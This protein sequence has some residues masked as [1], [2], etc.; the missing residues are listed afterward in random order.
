MR[1][2]PFAPLGLLVLT[3]YLAC[4]PAPTLEQPAPAALRLTHAHRTAQNGLT[5][6]GL[7]QNGLFQNGLFQNGL[8]QNGLFQNGLFQNSLALEALW[9][10]E[11]W[12]A[13]PAALAVLRDNV[14]AR[15]ALKYVY[16]CAK[17][18]AQSKIIALEGV[19][20]ELHGLIGLAPEPAQPGDECDE[21][22]QQR[23]VTACVL[24]RTN[25]YGLPV[26]ISMRAP[27]DAPATVKAALHVTDDE[28]AAYPL[29]EGA[30]YG[31]LF[32]Q[33]PRPGD[34]AVVMAPKFYGCAGPGSNIPQVTKRF[35]SSQGAGGPIRVPGTC[36]PRPE[37]PQS[38]C[39]G[40]SGD[41]TTGAMHDCYERVDPNAR[42]EHYPEVITVYLKQPIEVC[43]NSV[44]EENERLEKTCSSDCHPDSWATSFPSDLSVGTNRR[45]WA[46]TSTLDANDNIVIAG[47]DD[48]VIDLGAGPLD[49]GPGGTMR[50]VLAKYDPSGQI[51]WSERF[52]PFEQGITPAA[53]AVAPDGSIMVAL[54]S[55]ELSEQAGSIWLGKFTPEGK[56][57]WVKPF[58][59]DVNEDGNVNAV[60]DA[61]VVDR[62]G[63][64]TVAGHFYGVLKFG[65]TTLANMS[66]G[67]T[68][69]LNVSS[70][71][72]PR[73]AAGFWRGFINEP[74]RLAVDPQGN[75]LISIFSDSL[76][77]Q[78]VWKLAASSGDHLWS[79]R[80]RYWGVAA[81]ADGN[82]YATGELEHVYPL[83]MAYDFPLPANAEPG[84][85][86]V[87]KY[88]TATDT[89]LHSQVV[90]A[91][92]SDSVSYCAKHFEGR[93]LALDS[94][95]NVVVG[96]VGGNPG[97]TIDFG[98]GPFPT[99][100]TDDVFVV[101]F[102]PQLAPL[103]VKQV[104]MVLDGTE[105]GMYV[106]SHDHLIMSGTF[107]GSM[108]FDD[109]LLVSHIPEQ[110]E[111]GNTFLASFAVPSFSD[112]T[113]PVV[114]EPHLPKPTTL[115]ATSD[116]GAEV[117]FMPPTSLDSGH[118]GV[119]VSCSPPP[120]A[121]F[122][123]GTTVVTCTA[124]DPLGNHASAS[125]PVTVVDQLGPAFLNVPA[126]IT[127]TP[128]PGSASAVVTFPLPLALDQID[129][130]RAV[131]CTPASGSV[132]SVGT[133]EVTCS[134]ADAHGHLTEVSFDV[135]VADVVPPS[136][137]HVPAPFTVEASE[138]G[139]AR[140]TFELPLAFDLVDEN[141]PITCSPASGSVF[142]LGP[143]T[144]TCSASDA[145]GN[146]AQATFVVTVVDT[147]PPT[148]SAPEPIAAIA[149]SSQGA[150]VTYAASATDVASGPLTP[151]CSLPS[152]SLFPPGTTTVTCSATDPS[153]NTATRSFPVTVT[154]AWSGLLKPL[155]S[156]GQA[157]RVGTKLKVRFR[158]TEASAG[159]VDL[160]AT[161][162]AVKASPK[163]L[164]ALAKT[165]SPEALTGAMPFR[166]DPSKGWYEY[167][168][169][170]KSM[171][172]GEW[173]LRLQ[174]G[175]GV[176][177]SVQ[178]RLWR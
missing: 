138:A 9:Q 99:Y 130:S 54:D 171:A 35:C 71:G 67:A 58:G 115:E 60:V 51:L 45:P 50:G 40:V 74:R 95:G 23:W 43:G 55:G 46:K 102:S 87:V 72:T 91:S 106:N 126:P 97:G 177:R 169:A 21:I 89:L 16:E 93:E 31:N 131:T 128:P 123:L 42:G 159:I 145:Q 176:P 164:G 147:T 64:P 136:I 61:L 73:W 132:F 53:V 110:R 88:A 154:F 137:T 27:D 17:T 170:T 11:T 69:V 82:V 41:A 49:A 5:S 150:V 157:F 25:A 111:V 12:E 151:T 59:E 77:G 139:G 29:R 6:N 108:Q 174:F 78:G 85:F 142:P 173:D 127:V 100:A 112:E 155:D 103:W 10:R 107:S 65:D 149:T 143:T 141:V 57:V 13:N 166:Y 48:S 2:R 163:P 3:G 62:N 14:Y 83:D 47:A 156:D 153:G 160:P 167:E 134:A 140:P 114:A 37:F 119:S 124:T 8:F 113:P 175:D 86:F 172:P 96:V 158:L 162:S 63:N 165:P 104:P 94:A 81:D 101:A 26:D 20:L 28:R 122:P 4:T 34:G 80:G 32:R 144:V 1:L 22:C 152:G 120:N 75:V 38:A 105:R 109:H 70:Q 146:L 19:T 68:F 79:T 56:P 125:F 117:F 129:G 118:A 135:T 66:D 148:L 15:D 90:H 52:G 76:M 39:Q 36:E 121:V 30:F 92:C 116:A 133:R 178:I 161:L 33:A 18:P 24:A 44:C 168:L 84:D 7:F 98:T